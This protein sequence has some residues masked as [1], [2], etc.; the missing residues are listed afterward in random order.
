MGRKFS[1]GG[2]F[3][4]SLN[5]MRMHYTWIAGD[6][7]FLP[8]TCSGPRARQ[9]GRAAGPCRAGEDGRARGGGWPSTRYI[10]GAWPGTRRERGTNVQSVH[11]HGDRHHWSGRGGGKVGRKEGGRWWR[12]HGLFRAHTSN[13]VR[14]FYLLSR[15]SAGDFDEWSGET[16]WRREKR[17][18][19]GRE[20]EPRQK[21][22]G[23]RRRRRAG[24]L[25]ARE[26]S[27]GYGRRQRV[28]ARRKGE[29]GGK[30]LDVLSEVFD[31]PKIICAD[32]ATLEEER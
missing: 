14:A 32:A 10:T 27:H 13:H 17:K 11:I 23:R 26:K 7:N 5:E 18:K 8:W 12:F 4:C 31:I 16:R 22:R 30:S 20:R 28:T 21:C 29:R 15:A 19:F 24:R 3:I 9:G 1:G 2:A 25:C 6:I